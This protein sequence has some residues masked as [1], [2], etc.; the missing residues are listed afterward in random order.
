[1]YDTECTEYDRVSEMGKR[2]ML[3]TKYR[4]S[5]WH[6]TCDVVRSFKYSIAIPEKFVA[7]TLVSPLFQSSVV[8]RDEAYFH[9]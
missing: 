1:M 9:E 5:E 6:E 3:A 4:E 7:D 8:Q 2:K